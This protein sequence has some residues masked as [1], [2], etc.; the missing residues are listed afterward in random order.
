MYL[1]EFFPTLPE[2]DTSSVDMKEHT[3]FLFVLAVLKTSDLL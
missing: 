3:K 1:K 2:S